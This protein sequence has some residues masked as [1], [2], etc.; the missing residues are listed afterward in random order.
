MFDIWRKIG[1]KGPVSVSTKAT[2]LSAL[3]WVEVGEKYP[4]LMPE[5]FRGYDIYS[6]PQLIRESPFVRVGDR[7]EFHVNIKDGK[8]FHAWIDMR[9]LIES[10][11]A[12]DWQDE[13]GGERTILAC[14]CGIPACIG[15][16]SQTMHVSKAMVHWSIC[17]YEHHYEFFFDRE[18]YEV[19]LLRMLHDLVVN[20]GDIAFEHEGAYWTKE[21]FVEAVRGLLDRHPYFRDIWDE[22]GNGIRGA[23]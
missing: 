12:N 1:E 8:V 19:G 4:E 11:T 16:E 23:K 22:I 21:T 2:S 17:Q 6:D 18:V 14:S 9:Y 15:L 10:A 7:Y 20:G 13:P 3:G 5:K